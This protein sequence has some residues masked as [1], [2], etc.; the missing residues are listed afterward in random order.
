MKH[1][2]LIVAGLL[3]SLSANAQAS[4]LESELHLDQQSQDI[5]FLTANPEDREFLARVL[6]PENSRILTE[7]E[8]EVVTRIL[9][10]IRDKLSIAAK[11]MYSQDGF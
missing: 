7:E 5:I 9:S 4:V 10:D 3:G 11:P 6:N 1:V 2:I 8:K